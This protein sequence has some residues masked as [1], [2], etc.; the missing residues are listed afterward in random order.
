[1]DLFR[2]RGSANLR[3]P[4]TDEQKHGQIVNPPRYAHFGGLSSGGKA[5]EKNK[6]VVQKPG[7]GRKVI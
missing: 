3:K 1:M 5:V 6:M 7:D 2:P 4:T